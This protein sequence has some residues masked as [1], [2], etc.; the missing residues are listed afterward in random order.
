[1]VSMGLLI[2][3]GLFFGLLFLYLWVCFWLTLSL[4]IETNTQG[5][6]GTPEHEG[7]RNPERPGGQEGIHLLG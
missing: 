1:M 2:G 4:N 5:R 6:R 3:I 7:G